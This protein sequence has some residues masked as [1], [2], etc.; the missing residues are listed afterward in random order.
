MVVYFLLA[1]N[2]CFFSSAERLP[3][4]DRFSLSKIASM[5]AASCCLRAFYSQSLLLL[6]PYVTLIFG[7]RL[8]KFTNLSI[9]RL[10][11]A[12]RSFPWA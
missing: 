7:F 2:S 9:K 6:P 3:Y 1:S 4:P 12:V 10:M 11:G 5:L 8:P